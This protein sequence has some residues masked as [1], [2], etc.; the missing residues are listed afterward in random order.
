MC[1]I[2]QKPLCPGERGSPAQ[3]LRFPHPIQMRQLSNRS[4][5]KVLRESQRNP[6]HGKTNIVQSLAALA[7]LRI[8]HWLVG[9]RTSVE[10]IL[11]SRVFEPDYMSIPMNGEWKLQAQHSL[12]NPTCAFFFLPI[13]I[14]S[15]RYR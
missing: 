15:R 12:S 7:H 8:H 1:E 4:S 13:G 6:R 14:R 11:A 3:Q 10:A 5:R 9:G 2:R